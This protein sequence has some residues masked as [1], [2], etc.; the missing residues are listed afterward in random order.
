MPSI[1]AS[2]T[3]KLDRDELIYAAWYRGSLGYKLRPE[4]RNVLSMFR[5][6]PLGVSVPNLSRRYGKTTTCVVFANEEVNRRPQNITYATAFRTD[7]E[8]FLMPIYEQVLEDCPYK[9]RPKFHASSKSWRYPRGGSV[10]LVGVDKNPNGLRGNRIDILIM[11]EAGFVRNLAMLYRSILVPA[12]MKRQF[13]LIFPSTPPESPEHFWVK[14]LVPRAQKSGTYIHQTID[15]ISDLNPIERQR[16]LDEVGGEFST[17]AR[18]E[19][20]GEFVVDKM[21]AVAGGFNYGMHVHEY[22]PELCY[23]QLFGDTGGV[24]DMTVVL[25]GTFCHKYKK[26]IVRSEL[27]FDRTTPTPVI[28]KS[29]KET[30]GEMPISMDAAGQTRVDFGSL[31]LNTMLPQKDEFSAGIKLLDKTFYLNEIVIHPECTFLI[32]SLAGGLLNR[33]RTDY[34]RTDGLGH[35]DAIAAL[36]Y[37]I[38]SIDKR[39]H[40]PYGYGLDPSIYH[41]PDRIDPI[42]N[43]LIKLG[44]F[45]GLM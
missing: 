14:E 12:T 10:K 30:F 19:F 39:N 2:K 37:L 41:V 18:R 15:D 6:M 8:A 32:K 3:K 21:R 36:I 40:F 38:R 42:D 7:L 44:N 31:G 9:L 43:E 1:Q 13:K 4:Q 28:A 29:I 17:T 5:N 27:V 16:L 34:E 45:G 20:F 35:L 26:I 11:D 24:R 25:K 33:Q 22:T 23:W